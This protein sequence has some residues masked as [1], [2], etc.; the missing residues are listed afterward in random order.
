MLLRRFPASS[1]QAILLQCSQD[2]AMV[3]KI[4]QAL[5]PS[6]ERDQLVTLLLERYH[7]HISS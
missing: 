5:E 4:A 6:S 7:L 1:S 2:D 3:L